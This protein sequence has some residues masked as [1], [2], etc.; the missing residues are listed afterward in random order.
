M[1]TIRTMPR[2]T[3]KSVAFLIA[4]LLLAS[5]AGA[6]APRHRNRESSRETN[7]TASFDYYLLSLSWTPDFCALP[8]GFKDPRECGPG[9]RLGFTAH[10][11]WPQAESGRGPEDCAASPVAGAIVSQMLSYI[12]SPGLIQHEWSTHGSCSGLSVTDYFQRL[13]QARDKVKIPADLAAPGRDQT[14]SPRELAAWFAAANPAFPAS[15]FRATCTRGALQEVRVCFTKDLA[16]RP[17]S[18]SAGQCPAANI[19]VRRPL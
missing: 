15:A 4:A 19:L 12:P 11:L 8:G 1:R 9:R 10:G 17:C 13:R 7:I 6:N 18:G 16:P 3:S 14:V 2:R 5:A